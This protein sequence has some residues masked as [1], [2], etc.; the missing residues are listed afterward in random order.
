MNRCV[1]VCVKN[2]LSK[3]QCQV[4]A[5]RPVICMHSTR[6]QESVAGDQDAPLGAGGGGGALYLVFVSPQDIYHHFPEDGSRLL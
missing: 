5:F 2:A 4:S 1:C 6:H 3:T